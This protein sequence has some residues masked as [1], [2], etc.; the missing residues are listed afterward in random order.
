MS[1]ND[2]A[3]IKVVNELDGSSKLVFQYL[4]QV[5]DKQGKERAAALALKRSKAKLAQA[6]AS[7]GNSGASIT[8]LGLTLDNE[9]P[10]SPTIPN[11]PVPPPPPSRRIVSSA[12]VSDPGDISTGG[13]KVWASKE[14][15]SDVFANTFVTYVFGEIWRAGVTLDWVKGRPSGE[16]TLSWSC[17]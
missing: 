1:K 3:N 17:S 5:L 15:A 14:K 16:T 4:C 10:P 8:Q 13:I 12:S 6:T 2:V 9:P 11:K 7:T